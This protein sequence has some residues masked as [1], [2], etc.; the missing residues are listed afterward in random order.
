M[1]VR[2]RIAPSP[3]GHPHVGTL[4]MALFNL[5]FARHHGGDFLL[6]I[7]D[8][9][10]SRSRPEYETSI[11]ES[12]R[13][14]G[15]EWDEG[16]D[17][18]GS[19]GPYRQSERTE[20]YRKAVYDL[21]RAGKAYKC[22]TT[23]EELT[24][25]RLVA[26]KTGG[27]QGYDRRHRNLSEEEVKNFEAMGRPYVIRLK[28]PLT[29]DVVFDDA[30]KGRISAPCADIDD[31][32]LLKS[33]L[34]PTYH[35]ANV[36]DDHL[37]EISH[38]IRGDEW[39]SSTPKHIILYQ[40]FGWTPPTF[41]HMP[42]LLGMDGKKLSKRKNP[43]SAFYYKGCGYLPEAFRNFLTLMGYSMQDDKEIYTIEEITRQFDIKRIG[44]SGAVFDLKKLDWI[45]QQYMINSIKVEDL[46]P[47][48]REWGFNDAFMARLMPLAHTRIK[49]FGDFMDLCGFF[50]VNKLQYTKETLCPR[51]LEP[52]AVAMILQS[53]IWSL[54]EKEK[55]NKEDL[56]ASSREIS[57][58]FGIHFKKEMI[59]ILFATFTGKTQGPPLFDS[60]DILGPHKSRARILEGIEFLGGISN[61][62]LKD[63]EE[64]WA[65]K[66]CNSLISKAN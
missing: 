10:Q 51:G 20:L 11:Y 29:G 7:E 27:K 52:E 4:Y 62:K 6:R 66:Q 22:F 18:G 41:L 33:D 53:L 31:Q 3:T 15:I 47:R 39:L 61:K 35:L 54:D 26:Q 57:E 45:N 56:E 21:L 13:W 2:T 59:P 50:F 48:I 63:L 42:L 9:D 65:E 19:Y 23:A 32:V 36:V 60:F 34:F 17:V 43:T 5:I 46:W 14:A 12:L 58:I 37:M 16:P 40:A 64:G 8:T 30:V 24:E 49:T 38:V 28:V 1:K 44:L 25:M 55:W